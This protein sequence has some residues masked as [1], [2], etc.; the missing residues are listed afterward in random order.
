MKKLLLLLAIFVPLTAHGALKAFNSEQVGSTPTNGYVLQT[1]GSESQW[2]A[3]STLGFTS[4][5]AGTW[6]TKGSQVVGQ[7]INYSL[8]DT[9]I[10]TI[11]SNST[12]TSEFYFDPNTKTAVLG[13]DTGFLSGKVYT[14]GLFG[15]K[16]QV[17][18][19]QPV[20]DLQ[21]NLVIGNTYSG[22]DGVYATGGITFVNGRSSQGATFATSDYYTYLGLA[23]PNFAAFTGL[24]PNGF[25][26]SNTDGP[27]VIGAT[28]N[29][30]A[31]STIHLATGDGYATGN[32]DVTLKNFVAV[33]D[34]RGGNLGIGST[35]PYAKL[36]VVASSTRST[37]Y[38]HI[39]STTNTEAVQGSV[40]TVAGNG[41]VGIGTTSPYAKLSV[42]GQTVSEYFTATSTTAT[43]TF[44]G[45][46]SVGSTTPAGNALFRVGTSTQNLFVSKTSGKVGIGALPNESLAHNLQLANGGA[47]GTNIYSATSINLSP[48]LTIGANS[49]VLLNPGSVSNGVGISSTTPWG[50][51]SVNPNGISGPSFVVG[52]STATHFTVKNNGNVGVSTTSPWRTFS[53][54]GTVGFDGLTTGAGGSLCL[55]ETTKEVYLNAGLTSCAVSSIRYKENVSSLTSVLD[56]VLKLRPVTYTNKSDKQKNVGL[57]AEEVYTLFP[58]AVSLDKDGIPRGVKYENL[59]GG[60]L[61]KAIQEQQAKINS[62]EARIKQLEDTINKLKD[63][64]K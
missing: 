9:D 23:G 58:D 25:V 38:F 11:G 39:A 36:T 31:S 35:S 26:M 45:V 17:M 16:T 51:L 6:A 52:S 1:T 10:V 13:L 44:G 18:M 61:V 57:I 29:N 56:K 60:I 54:T 30:N 14:N 59:A 34:A 7:L 8:N 33:S 3:T 32:Y 53:V 19:T 41:N 22:A 37:P 55:N 4:G 24:P 46:L 2:V 21:S 42:V 27:I 5:S 48:N 20:N 43:S 64:L 49:N 15:T 62:Q 50:L 47:I 63:S 40:F 28:S 12:T